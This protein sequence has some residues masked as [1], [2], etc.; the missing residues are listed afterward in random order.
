MLWDV[1]IITPNFDERQPYLPKFWL[2]KSSLHLIWMQEA[3]TNRLVTRN[4]AR[5]PC[6]AAW[7]MRT[8]A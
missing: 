3:F 7:K 4:Y 2:M 8:A 5:A 6:K 1:L